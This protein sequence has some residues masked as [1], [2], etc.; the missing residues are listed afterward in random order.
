MAMG[1]GAESRRAGGQG[2]RNND[3][4]RLSRAGLVMAG[5]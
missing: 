1:R 2:R 4:D 5:M 3:L